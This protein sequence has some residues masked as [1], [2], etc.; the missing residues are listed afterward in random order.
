MHGCV[1]SHRPCLVLMAFCMA[2]S[3]HP[4]SFLYNY[5]EHFFGN[6]F[7]YILIHILSSVVQIRCEHWQKVGYNYVHAH[8]RCVYLCVY[9]CALTIS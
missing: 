2:P 8:R 1:T 7:I 3:L 5:S 9:M 4:A 6:T